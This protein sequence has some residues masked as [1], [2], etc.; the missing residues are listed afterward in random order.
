MTGESVL[1]HGIAERRAIV[2]G[3]GSGIDP[4]FTRVRR[5]VERPADPVEI[6]AVVAFL[7]SFTG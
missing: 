1:C 3:T 2:P 7:C 4:P 5:S 6:A